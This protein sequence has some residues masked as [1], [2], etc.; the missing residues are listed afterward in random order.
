M[1]VSLRN[2]E[3][4]SRQAPKIH[5]VFKAQ[6]L[7]THVQLRSGG[8]TSATAVAT[9]HANA[10]LGSISIVCVALFPG[11]KYTIPSLRKSMVIII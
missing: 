9:V 10:R 7:F 3:F 11:K 2:S 8:K 6:R 5:S 1:S 4:P